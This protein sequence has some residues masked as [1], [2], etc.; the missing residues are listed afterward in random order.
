MC[1][2]YKNIKYMLTTGWAGGG[3]NICNDI[4]Y[5]DKNILMDTIIKKSF[6]R[7]EIAPYSKSQNASYGL[8]YSSPRHILEYIRSFL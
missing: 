3:R 1:M 4:S 7:Q 2:I 5:N 8:R 6:C